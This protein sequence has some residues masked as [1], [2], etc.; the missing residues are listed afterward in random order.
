MT[1]ARPL[2]PQALRLL[3]AISAHLLD[4][5]PWL[6]WLDAFVEVGPLS[7]AWR[8]HLPG[9]Q[10]L[11]HELV[12]RRARATPTLWASLVACGLDVEERSHAGETALY[13]AVAFNAAATVAALLAV[14]AHPR[15]ANADGKEP[16][17]ALQAAPLWSDAIAW[18]ARELTAAGAV[19]HP[20]APQRQK[21]ALS[22]ALDL[23]LPASG[24]IGNPRAIAQVN[25]WARPEH[26]LAWDH[27]DAQATEPPLTLA[28]ERYARL[29]PSAAASFAPLA[30]FLSQQALLE[31]TEALV[32]S[33]QPRGR[34]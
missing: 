1:A 10:P 22:T 9:R 21:S 31:H 12:L 25:A 7:A 2:S 34:L 27:Q 16:M 4:E 33:P 30:S 5:D 6:E 13:S 29:D 19:L 20:T 8:T 23:A 28:A 18:I 24:L 32:R 15:S 3:K 26:R 11:V 14:G 17:M